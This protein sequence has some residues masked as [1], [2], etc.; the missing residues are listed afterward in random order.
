MPVGLASWNRAAT[1]C[2]GCL[3]QG[4]TSMSRS[5]RRLW[6]SPS[7]TT[8]VFIRPQRS[9][10]P[11]AG[12]PDQTTIIKRLHYETMTVHQGR[13]EVGFNH[14]LPDNTQSQW[15][16][17]LALAGWQGRQKYLSEDSA[18][19]EVLL[20][21]KYGH[22]LLGIVA[23]HS[24]WLAKKPNRKLL[25]LV[26]RNLEMLVPGHPDV[27]V[28]GALARCKRGL[29]GLGPVDGNPRLTWPPVFEASY[30][31]AVQ[32][33]WDG[34]SLLEPGRAAARIASAL[35]TGTVWSMWPGAQPAS[36]AEEEEPAQAEDR[37]KT[38]ILG[39][40]AVGALS[41]VPALRDLIDTLGWGPRVRT[42]RDLWGRLAASLEPAV[43]LLVNQA[44]QLY[45]FAL[46]RKK[47]EDL[48]T[49]SLTDLGRALNLPRTELDRAVTR[50]LHLEAVEDVDP[51]PTESVP[52]ATAGSVARDLLTP[53][54]WP[55]PDGRRYVKSEAFGNLLLQEIE[56]LIRR[57]RDLDFTDGAAQIFTWLDAKLRKNRRFLNKA[58]FPSEGAFRAYIRQAVWNAARLA[59]RRRKLGQPLSAAAE[60]T[61]LSLD[62]LE[63]AALQE[64]LDALQEPH[65]TVL[66][67][68]Y[69]GR[70]DVQMV[71]SILDRTAQQVE[72]LFREALDLLRLD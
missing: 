38:E 16:M 18:E 62:P 57:N 72:Q 61:D 40:W 70:E 54:A 29:P 47:L 7:W 28:L 50:C 63:L 27:L 42:G 25:A 32:L 21:D 4:L 20:D 53:G 24:L 26:Q 11:L 8:M 6:V 41:V 2:I 14:L 15:A 59:Q 35:L 44:E 30:R 60:P 46:S 5:F 49:L 67:K 48:R 13:L 19:M 37:Q 55:P 12:T 64:S 68:L 3:Q 10:L 52:Q 9:A 56:P 71:A 58:R 51:L 1:L 23:A 17:E 66:E 45:R 43:R 65:K 69:F 39:A 34:V 31:M 33:D 22:P 36:A